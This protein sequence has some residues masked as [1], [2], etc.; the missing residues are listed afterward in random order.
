METFLF[1]LISYQIQE[2]TA[3]QLHLLHNIEIL[4]NLLRAKCHLN[5]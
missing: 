2:V 5:Y 1:S 3:R 4:S